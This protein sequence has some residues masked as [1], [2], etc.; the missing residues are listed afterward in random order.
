MGGRFK[1]FLE[2]APPLLLPLDRAAKMTRLKVLHHMAGQPISW[3]RWEKY[4]ESSHIKNL[5]KDLLKDSFAVH[6]WNHCRTYRSTVNR[7]DGNRY[8]TKTWSERQ[9]L[10]IIAEREFLMDPEHLLYRIFTEN[11]PVTEGNLLAN[12]IG[13]PY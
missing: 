2:S 4:F 11:C 5:N 1:M 13:S 12:L 10:N 8:G 6:Y 9:R 7:C 3:W